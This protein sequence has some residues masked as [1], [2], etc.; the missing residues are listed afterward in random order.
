MLLELPYA[1][2]EGVTLV[3]FVDHV[4]GDV[5]DQLGTSVETFLTFVAKKVLKLVKKWL[6]YEGYNLLK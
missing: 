4:V 6:N 5:S 1:V 2:E 3:T